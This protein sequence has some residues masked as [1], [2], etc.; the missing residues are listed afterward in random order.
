MARQNG[1]REYGFYGSKVWLFWVEEQWGADYL[2]T[3]ARSGDRKRAC[4][5]LM[6]A[7]ILTHLCK[8][9]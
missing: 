6:V 4:D 9:L 2:I 8:S 3:D 7:R 5:F 1:W